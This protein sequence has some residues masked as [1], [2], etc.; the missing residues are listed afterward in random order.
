M[1]VN[2]Y[3]LGHSREKNI[4]RETKWESRRPPTRWR[5]AL[6]ARWSCRTTRPV[7]GPPAALPDRSAAALTER[8]GAPDD[9][10]DARRNVVLAEH[11]GAQYLCCFVAA[12][13]PI[14]MGRYFRV[15]PSSPDAISCH[16]RTDGLAAESPRLS[17]SAF[18]VFWFALQLLIFLILKNTLRFLALAGMQAGTPSDDRGH[19]LSMLAVV[20]FA[21]PTMCTYMLI[22]LAVIEANAEDSFVLPPSYGGPA[23]CLA[24]TCKLCAVMVALYFGCV[25]GQRF[26]ATVVLWLMA[27]GLLVNLHP[28]P[29]ALG[30][31]LK[32][33]F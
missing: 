24:D 22:N 27:M 31:V 1:A 7:P 26:L 20:L 3:H 18:F 13:V 33:K 29:A 30:C 8:S 14:N 17:Y 5:A 10:A 4:H 6:A 11:R 12:L 21:P 32:T 28:S 9:E 23:M 25:A 2:V 16:F 19:Q 15:L